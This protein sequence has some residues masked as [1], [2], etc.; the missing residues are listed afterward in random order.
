M[1]MR[2]ASKVTVIAQAPFNLPQN[3]S[4]LQFSMVINPPSGSTVQ[5]PTTSGVSNAGNIGSGS[6]FSGS[7]ATAA[8]ASDLQQ[9]W[10]AS[11]TLT[12]PCNL[13]IYESNFAPKCTL[14]AQRSEAIQ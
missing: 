13:Y 7:S 6:S 4:G 11:L 1:D 2:R 12:Y 5:N 14:A 3:Q 10:N 9:S 8:P